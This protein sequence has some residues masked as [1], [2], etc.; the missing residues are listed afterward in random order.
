[1][2]VHLITARFWFNHLQTFYPF[3][4][5]IFQFQYLYKVETN[6]ASVNT[7]VVC[8]GRSLYLKLIQIKHASPPSKLS[9]N[10][11]VGP[12]PIKKS[13]PSTFVKNSILV[14]S[15]K[16]NKRMHTHIHTP[17]TSCIVVFAWHP[18]L[19]LRVSI[20]TVLHLVPLDSSHPSWNNTGS[21]VIMQDSLPYRLRPRTSLAYIGS[22]LIVY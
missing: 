4:F 16:I 12:P 19:F 2:Y 13:N 20:S 1:M 15:I 14:K 17:R 18:S 6:C 7:C 3:V 10:S 5:Y 9:I 22:H 8:R 21:R 11:I